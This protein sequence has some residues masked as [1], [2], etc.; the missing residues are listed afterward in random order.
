VTTHSSASNDVTIPD[1]L[2]SD[3]TKL[4]KACLHGEED[5]WETLLAKYKNL[6]FSIPIKYGFSPEEAAD[7]FQSVCLDLVY[8]LD[9]LREPR[10]LAGWLIRI[11][12][13][14]CYHFQKTKQRNVRNNGSLEPSIASEEVLENRLEDLQREQALRTAI[15]SLSPQ[16]RKLIQMLFFESP[17]RPYEE[18]ARSLTMA[19][20]SIGPIRSRCL[21]YLRRRL[22]KLGFV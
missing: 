12:C 8:E 7:I 17:A 1:N 3:D 18:I 5:A 15:H 21:D 14:K 4:V 16:C 10:A 20:G 2:W 9:S 11:T 22:E 6:I 19:K 13:N